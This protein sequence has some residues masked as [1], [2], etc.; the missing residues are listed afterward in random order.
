MKLRNLFFVALTT[1][2]LVACGSSNKAKSTDVQQNQEQTAEMTAQDMIEQVEQILESGDKSIPGY[3]VISKET[4]T[5]KLYDKNN[6][7]IYDFPVAVGRNY[8]NKTRAHD[9]KTPEGEF[10]IQQIQPSSDWTHDFGDGKGNIQGAYGPYFIR[11]V[12]PPFKGIGIHGTHAPESIGT[13]ATEGCIRLNNENVLLLQPL[14]KT[15]MKVIIETSKKDM[16]ADGKKVEDIAPKQDIVAAT[17]PISKPAEAVPA[18]QEKP[19]AA[20]TVAATDATTSTPAA[21]AAPATP[22]A[23]QTPATEYA[24]GEIIEHTVEKGQ[25]VG[26]IAIKYN[27]STS[28]ILELNPGLV[29]E[30]I[31]IGQKIKVQPNTH[32]K[33]TTPAVQEDPTG[34]YHTIVKGDMLGKIAQTYGTTVAKLKELNPDIVET[35]LKLGS[36]IRVK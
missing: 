23:E 30:K 11:L 5:L 2:A 14:V 22:A 1:I 21:P 34:T 12:T 13:R 20:T 15:G 17:E 26:H 10:T 19:A 8:G 31:Q 9:M 27:T 25:L 6:R 36:K 7:I 28:K 18:T 16:E 29:P 24:E 3:I 35:N 32:K 4:M 33:S